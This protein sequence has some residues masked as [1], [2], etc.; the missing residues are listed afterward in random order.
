MLLAGGTCIDRQL[1][2]NNSRNMQG[3]YVYIYMYV[4]SKTT[5]YMY[6]HTIHA[7]FVHTQI[8]TYLLILCTCTYIVILQNVGVFSVTG[9]RKLYMYNMMYVYSTLMCIRKQGS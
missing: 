2:H 8:Y 5:V 3:R 1:E 6:I 7:Q 4:Y 9:T